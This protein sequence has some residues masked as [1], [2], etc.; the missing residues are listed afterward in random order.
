MAEF[1]YIDNSNVFIESKRV[2]AVQKGLA[3]D[4]WE[5]IDNQI[6]DISYRMDFGH[7]HDFV[8]GNDASRIKRAMLFGSRPPANDSLLNLARRAGFEVVVEDRNAASREKKID[9]GI[10]A[11]MT[12]YAYTKTDKDRDTITLVAGDG[13]YVPAIR[14]LVED[15]FRAEVVFW[16]H[17][18]QELKTVCRRFVDLDSHLQFLSLSS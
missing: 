6:L 10:I 15:G 1:V 14:Q 8:A 16:G 3:L 2:S 13:D 18:S 7:L 9:T 12:R 11:A 4:I 5:A 17:A